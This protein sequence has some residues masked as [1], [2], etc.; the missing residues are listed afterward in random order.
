MEVYGD[1]YMELN[2]EIALLKLEVKV[3]EREIEELDKNRTRINDT[4]EYERTLGMVQYLQW[5]VADKKAKL[6]KLEIYIQS[7]RY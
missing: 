2:E 3:L 5:E 1:A 7:G 6:A 4:L